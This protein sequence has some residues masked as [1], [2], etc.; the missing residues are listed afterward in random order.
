[1]DCF[2]STNTIHCLCFLVSVLAVIWILF[3]FFLLK[4]LFER[5]WLKN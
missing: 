2:D 4:R 3:F 1:M 5:K